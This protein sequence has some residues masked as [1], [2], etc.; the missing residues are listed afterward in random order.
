VLPELV[1]LH[2]HSDPDVKYFSGTA[3]YSRRIDVPTDFIAPGKR[4]VLDLGRLEV[5]AR[6]RANGRDL[7][8][9]WKEP[10]RLDITKAV[11][12]GTNELEIAVTSLWPNRMIGDEQLPAENRYGQG[13]ERGI[14]EIPDWYRNGQPKPPGGRTTFVTW[15]FFHKDDPLLAS[16]LLGPVRLWNPVVRTLGQ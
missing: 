2:K 10:Y 9:L 8:V 14:V 16:G 6:V 4:V 13:A 12:P 7:G 1:S 15:Q 5:I 11:H 3:T